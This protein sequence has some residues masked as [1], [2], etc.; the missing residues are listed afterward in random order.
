MA[1]AFHQQ[2][3]ATCTPLHL[4]AIG[5]TLY[6]R[7]P[8]E[9][10]A[11]QFTIIETINAPGFGPPLHRHRE[12]EIFRVLEG[13]YLYEVDGRRFHA[14]TGDV[15]IIPGGAAH[16]FRNVAPTPSRQFITI[17]P[18]LDAAGFFGGLAALMAGSIPDKAALNTFGAAWK[19]EFLG[20][21]LQET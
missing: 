15:V 21:P 20:P 4:P 1:I 18:A 14:G 9:A 13:R 12:A 6:V 17:T 3:A 11:N 8:P 16:A 5:L 2:P 19:V 10:T 7:V